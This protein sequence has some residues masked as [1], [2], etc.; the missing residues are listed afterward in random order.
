MRK[1]ASG[2]RLV[3]GYLGIFLVFEGLVT[4]FPLLMLAFYPSEYQCWLDFALPAL[5]SCLLGFALFFGFL[6]K[7]TKG[8]L[9]NH[10]D[11]L[12][13]VLIWLCAV[14]FGALPFYLSQFEAINYGNASLSL[15]MN[16]SESFFESTSGFTTTGLSVMP[17]FSYLTG[18][19][20]SLYP[21]AHV[22]LFHRAFEQFIGGVGLVLIVASVLSDRYNLKLYFAEG[23]NDK[24][25]PNLGRSAKLIF[26]IYSSYVIVGSLS[27]WL[28]GMTPFDAICH[29]ASALSTGG[30]STR[31][32]NYAFWSDAANGYTGNG[33]FPNNALA[34]EIITEV[35]MLLGAT[36]FTLHTFLFRGKLKQFCKDIEI[37]LAFWLIVAFSLACTLSSLYLSSYENISF[38]ASLRY[39]VFTIISSITT[40]GY[41]TVK[42]LMALGEVTILSSI[43]LMAVGAGLGSTGGGIKQFRFSILLKDFF[44][45]VRYHFSSSHLIIPN[46]IHRL[47]EY[48][49]EDPSVR[50]EA[51]SYTL[52]FILFYL[53]GAMGLMF[54][55]GIDFEHGAYEF[56]SALSDTG[57]SLTDYAAYKAGYAIYDYNILMWILSLGMFFGRLEILPVHFALQRLVA[58][59][60]KAIRERPRKAKEA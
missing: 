25:M 57:L 15:N 24:L 22:F 54:L 38:G 53:I 47:G 51:H 28:A 1:E 35:L 36:N 31:A 42:S 48:K 45:S 23:H 5:G 21:A 60:I 30:F 20:S 37:R 41:S 17:S 55:P 29:S 39:N 7:R 14:V 44:Y 33:I 3:L 2:Y 32:S 16:F 12:L 19:D 8:R 27:L 50:D 49:E 11:A 26:G 56:M 18:L 10:E 52:I 40:T 59:P 9:A 6:G 46:P 34:L 4:A 43:L 58:D 13:L